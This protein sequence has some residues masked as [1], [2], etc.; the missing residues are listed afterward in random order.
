MSVVAAPGLLL[1]LASA[2]CFGAMGIFGKLAYEQGSTVGTLLVTRFAVSSLVLWAVLA[3]SGRLSRVRALSRSDLVLALGLGAVGY[4]AQ[5]GA[6]FAALQRI[7]PGLLALLLYT[8]PAIVTVA[9]IRLGREQASRRTAAALGLTSAG[10]VL[11]LAGAGGGA[12]DPIGTL[13]GLTAA[14]VYATYIL[15]ADGIATRIGPIVLSTLVCTGATATLTTGGIVAHN[16]EVNAVTAAGFGWLVAIAVV[17]TV[18]AI[19]LFFAG[20]HRVGPTAASILSTFEPLVTVVLAGLAFGDTLTPQQLC[21][22]LLIVGGVIALNVRRRQRPART[23]VTS[24]EVG[25]AAP[26]QTTTAQRAYRSS[27]TV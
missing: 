4:S 6:Y 24:L 25:C 15:T 5:A 11:V 7:N 2:A 21:G 16:L 26:V 20:L 12:L 27:S 23:G 10:L 17:S 13:L 1:C 19:A 3:T 22:G 18:A 9:A 14:V 8:F